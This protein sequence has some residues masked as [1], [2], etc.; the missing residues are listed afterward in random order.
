[1]KSS[2]PAA[3]HVNTVTKTTMQSIAGMSIMR[4]N[5]AARADMTM[6]AVKKTGP[7]SLRV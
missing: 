4:M 5:M 1:M 7:S 3:K 6:T 2:V